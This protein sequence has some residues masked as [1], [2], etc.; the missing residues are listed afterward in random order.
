LNSKEHKNQPT[1]LLNDP[2]IMDI[3]CNSHASYFYK[4]NGDFFSFG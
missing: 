3:C 1:L 2:E 4:T